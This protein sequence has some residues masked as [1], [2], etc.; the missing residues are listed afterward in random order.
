M[1]RVSNDSKNSNGE[2]QDDSTDRDRPDRP[3]PRDVVDGRDF[4]D[5]LMG[6]GRMD[7][8][9]SLPLPGE[10]PTGPSEP[11]PDALR[12]EDDPAMKVPDD[13]SSVLQSDEQTGPGDE[14]RDRSE[15]IGT[16]ARWAAGWS[17]RFLV[18]A[19]A[20]WVFGMVLAQ[21][22]VG[23][24]PVVLALIICTVLWPLVRLFRRWRIPNAL[25]V[26]LTILS[27]VAVIAG[28]IAVIAPPVRKQIP[29]LIDSGTAGV[30]TVLDWVAGPPLNLQSD[31][32]D[33]MLD[34]ATSWL[35]NQTDQITQTATTAVSA[36]TSGVVTMF[37]MLVLIFF[38]LKDGER[39]LPMVRRITGRR[40]GWHLTEVL[41]RCWNTLGGFIRT[42][43]IVSFIDAFFIGLG[44]VILQVP[45]WGPLAVITFFGGFIPIVGA[46]T[47][48]ALAVLVALVAH[49]FTTALIVLGVVLAVQQ[50]EGNILQPV[51]QSKAMNMHAAVVL[52]SV[53][54]G[55]TIYGIIGA[56]LAVPVAAMII[57]VLRYIG[58]MTDLATGEKHSTDIKFATTAGQSTGEQREEAAKR[59]QDWRRSLIE[60]E[61]GEPK[62]FSRFLAPLLPDGKD[63]KND[64][65]DSEDE[66]DSDATSNQ[67]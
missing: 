35:E 67:S 31:Q 1:G 2:S 24:L 56:F 26:L 29:E 45:L 51:L 28:V 44:L 47:A 27:F 3:D 42:Q 18:I 52:L 43:A 14:V 48:G 64:A 4:A 36:V 57:E 46:F 22:W 65:N 61:S 49:G 30:Q 60:D 63:D 34:Q 53:T 9:S 11:A 39:F 19:A 50:L 21:L 38:F 5:I 41:T 12:L 13:Q 54:V 10:E 20:F 16:S 66:P 32:L 33:N 37:V 6:S 17:L 8:E 40:V 58:D 59:W 15:V 25:S 62:P 23:I 7:P 55:G